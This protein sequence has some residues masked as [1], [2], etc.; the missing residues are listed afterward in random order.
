MVEV[1][2]MDCRELK[3][4]IDSYISDELLVETNHEVLGHLEN[5][6]AC[7]HE[8]AARRSLRNRIGHTVIN[9]ELSRIDP[10]FAAGV[11][12]HLRE[13]ALRPGFWSGISGLFNIR[14]A[15]AGLAGLIILTIG[16]LVFLNR[17]NVSV[18]SVGPVISQPDNTDDLV[19]ADPDPARAILASWRELT[20]KAVGD[21]LNCAV[22]FKLTDKPIS[23]DEAAKKYSAFDKGLSEAVAEA[24]KKV[25]GGNAQ[26]P[27]DILE[28]H[29][30]IFEGRR[31]AHIVIR[32]KGQLISVLVTDTD[33]SAGN[34]E[35]QTAQIDGTINTAGFRVG[36]HAVFVVS[37]LPDAENIIVA[38]AVAPAIRLQSEKVGT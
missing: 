8:L 10:A 34:D 7:R 12:T 6:P 22:E 31:F 17:N 18:E 16:G 1:T 33:Q 3:D 35:I 32:R 20:T 13:T 37:Q 29:S 26:E 19:P 14:I 11:R 24:V 27:V 2:A 15:A 36:R 23:L 28:A 21:H 4:L 5:C 25:D 38:K 30:C 9:A